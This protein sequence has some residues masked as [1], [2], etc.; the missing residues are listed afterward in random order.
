MRFWGFLLLFVVAFCG[1]GAVDLW[2]SGFWNKKPW[3]DF[4]IANT[5]TTQVG[6]T[7]AAHMD[8]QAKPAHVQIV[9]VGDVMLGS[10][11]P[12]RSFLPKHDIHT[13]FAQVLPHLAGDVVFANLE[14]T[15]IDEFATTQKCSQLN[16]CFAFAMPAR[17]G[18]VLS[19]AGFTV[20]SLANNH[21]ND[22][23]RLGRTSTVFELEMAN[24]A[25]AG[26]ATKP[27]V[28]FEKNGVRYGFAAFAP[29]LHTA[30]IHDLDTA[31]RR[32]QALKQKTDIVLV[33]FH[34]GAEGAAYTRVPKKTEW[35]LGENRGDVYHFAHAM[36]DAG[37]DVVLGH[38]PHVVR[39]IELYKGRLIA[40][41]LGNFSTHGFA[42]Q[43]VYGHAP[44]LRMQLD[45][46]GKLL[47]AQIISAKQ[48]AS[49]Q[50]VLDEAKQAYRQIKQLTALDFPD[51][52]LYFGQD[53]SILP[54]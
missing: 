37:A 36:V 3:A 48:T 46:Q 38:G 44:I 30:S 54:K 34:G 22:F 53:G 43:G 17:Y 51:T 31:V 32:V 20:V 10:W 29:N 39:A 18:R 25:A 14:G 6:L 21:I 42:V 13:H 45:I 5:Q 47:S 26:L 23:G 27:E 19:A 33:S 35:F 4:V 40:Y 50:L 11:Y 52:P 7:H 1:F 9:A 12:N 8:T 28:I 2:L 16:N 41:S 49:H 15:L 24:I